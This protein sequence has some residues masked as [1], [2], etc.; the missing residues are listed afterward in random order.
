MRVWS[1]VTLLCLVVGLV[2]CAS[3][4]KTQ[5]PASKFE[6]EVRGAME[7]IGDFVDGRDALKEA[8]Q[9][10]QR[11]QRCFSAGDE[12]CATAALDRSDQL[13]GKWKR[14]SRNVDFSQYSRRVYETGMH[15]VEG[16]GLVG[17]G[18]AR[19]AAGWEC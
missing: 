19:S 8:S 14:L 11:A 13:E 7:M 18:C 1:A 5:T 9:E 4:Q 15:R 10:T 12:A 6:S 16:L 3:D 17:Q 2:A